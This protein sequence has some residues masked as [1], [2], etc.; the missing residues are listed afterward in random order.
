MMATGGMGSDLL[1]KDSGGFVIGG[2]ASASRVPYD[3]SI[4]PGTT[5]GA[6]SVSGAGTAGAVAIFY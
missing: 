2:W 3:I 4:L 1:F 6:G 5:Y